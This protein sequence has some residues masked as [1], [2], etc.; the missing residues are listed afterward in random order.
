MNHIPNPS[1]HRPGDLI[2]NR[3]MP[4]ATEEECE[5]ARENLREFAVVVVG[6]AKRL[7]KEESEHA[8]EI[9][10]ELRAMIEFESP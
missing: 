9:L 6:I 3:Y 7:A 5:A 10:G 8:R 2:L 1:N 4:D